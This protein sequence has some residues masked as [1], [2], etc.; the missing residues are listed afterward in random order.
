MFLAR[1]FGWLIH[2]LPQPPNLVVWLCGRG[3]K[4]CTGHLW[5]IRVQWGHF[6]C[7][8]R[9][10]GSGRAPYYSHWT[11]LKLGFNSF[12]T[13]KRTWFLCP[14]CLRIGCFIIRRLKVWLHRRF[15]HFLRAWSC[16]VVGSCHKSAIQIP[17]VVYSN[18]RQVSCHDPLATVRGVELP[19]ESCGG[20]LGRSFEDDSS[21][22]CLWKMGVDWKELVGISVVSTGLCC[23]SEGNALVRTRYSFWTLV[24]GN[25]CRNFDGGKIFAVIMAPTDDRAAS[26]SSNNLFMMKKDILSINLLL[27]GA[28]Q[29]WVSHSILEASPKLCLF[30]DNTAACR[31]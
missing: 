28:S 6:A 15:D 4:K 3:R 22:V 26:W 14:Q 30:A 31:S 21:T 16:S 18:N 19:W 25:G 27:N 8:G 11:K 17:R 1:C 29:S 7:P 9:G 12:S 2:V 10:L 24:R 20:K 13:S 5:G 23:F